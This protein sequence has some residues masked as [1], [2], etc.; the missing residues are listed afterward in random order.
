MTPEERI[1]MLL[2]EN[3]M[4]RQQLAGGNPYAEHAG[5]TSRG[6]PNEYG[7]TPEDYD[8]AMAE[9]RMREEQAYMGG[10]LSDLKY[11]QRSAPPKNQYLRKVPAP[12]G[13]SPVGID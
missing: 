2:E 6:M 9:R 11:R 7:Q 8:A 4:L 10:G 13:P 5:P 12:R 3:A 1:R